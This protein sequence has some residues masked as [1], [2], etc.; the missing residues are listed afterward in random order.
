MTFLVGACAIIFDERGRVLLS[1][2]RDLDLWNLPG[3]GVESGEIPTEAAVRETKEETGLDIA[4]ERLVGVYGKRDK[5][6]IVFA[7]ACCVVGG[8]LSIT[9][10][11]DTHEYFAVDALPVN[12][13]PKQVARIH[14]AIDGGAQPVFRLQAGPSAREWLCELGSSGKSV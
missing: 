1:H 13:I 14:D 11:A 3:G 5:D 2:R 12:T 9:D 8:A 10:E 4:I 7:F 6:E